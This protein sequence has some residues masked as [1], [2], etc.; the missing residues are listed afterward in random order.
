[1]TELT[2]QQADDL[3]RT[4]EYLTLQMRLTPHPTERSRIRAMADTA[5]FVAERID[6]LL[7]APPAEQRPQRTQRTHWTPIGELLRRLPLGL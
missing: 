5:D 4:A 6:A 7:T 3:R 1:M 2:K